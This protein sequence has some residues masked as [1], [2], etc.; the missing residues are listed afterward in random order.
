MP[1]RLS[2]D[3][4]LTSPEHKNLVLRCTLTMDLTSVPKPVIVKAALH[5]HSDEMLTDVAAL[6]FLADVK[7]ELAP[8]VLAFD[9]EHSV[10]VMENVNGIPLF[11]VL[12]GTQESEAHAAIIGLARCLV[13]PRRTPRGADRCV[14]VRGLRLGCRL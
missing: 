3:R 8:V 14:A 9:A 6:N 1:V 13:P 5:A 4:P 7:R 11:D 10:L 12:E 2:L